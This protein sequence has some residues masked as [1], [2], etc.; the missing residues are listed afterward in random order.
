MKQTGA[1]VLISLSIVGSYDVPILVVQTWA[2]PAQDMTL[3]FE[4]NIPKE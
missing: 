1:V 3:K 4:T 2:A